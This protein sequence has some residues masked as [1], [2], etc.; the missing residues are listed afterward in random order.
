MLPELELDNPKLK[1]LLAV[2]FSVL[3]GIDAVGTKARLRDNASRP[4]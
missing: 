4:I 2:A 1:R 3:L